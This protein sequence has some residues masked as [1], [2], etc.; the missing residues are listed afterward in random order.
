M[1]EVQPIAVDGRPEVGQPVQGGAALGPII[2]VAL[3]ADE[4]LQD[5]AL[6]P[7]GQVGDDRVAPARRSQSVFQIREAIR[8]PRDLE[9]ADHP[10]LLCGRTRGETDP[11]N[12]CESLSS[13][14][15]KAGSASATN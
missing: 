9:G 5:P 12:V 4:L 1:Q 14:T 10:G 15:R 8:V 6:H 7:I 13:S 3:I 11:R 2:L